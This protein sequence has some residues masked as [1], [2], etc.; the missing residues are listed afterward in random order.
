MAHP[1]RES[2]VSEVSGYL[3]KKVGRRSLEP[4]GE[5]PEAFEPLSAEQMP[6]RARVTKEIGLKAKLASGA[7][8]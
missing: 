1:V 8:V 7:L 2:A 5:T 6:K 4:V 3:R